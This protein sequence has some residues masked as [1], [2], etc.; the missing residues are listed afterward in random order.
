MTEPLVHGQPK[1][2]PVLA[3]HRFDE[4]RLSDYLRTRLPGFGGE[5]VVQQFQGGQS[6][7]TYAI[8]AAGHR[9]VLRKKPPGKLLPSAHA[10]ERE[11][12]VM[13]ALSATDVP[14]PAMRLLIEDPDVIGTPFFLMDHIDGRVL[15]DVCLPSVA[16]ENRHAYYDELARVM[17][18]LHAVDPIAVGLGDFGRPTNYIA[19]QIDRWS[20][21]YLL[22]KPEDAPAMDRLMEWLPA[23]IPPD[24]RTSV[25]HGDYRLGNMLFHLTEPRVLAVLDWEL[26][27]LGH[28]LADLAYNC[29][30][31]QLPSAV[32][33]IADVP[34]PGLPSQAEYLRMYERHSGKPLP[35]LGYYIVFSLFRWAAIAAGVYRRALDGNAADARGREAGEK[36]KLLAEVAWERVA[37]SASVK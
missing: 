21:Q 22:S 18:A 20:K 15:I 19:R 9:Y 12:R 33:G 8:N 23:H 1:L 24:E 11:F 14:V 16:R 4:A 37:A 35:D 26:A 31:W 34:T 17:A 32:G 27:T 36:Y 29:L 6:N 5:I 25:V 7:P 28:P 10:V 3:N 2:V 13:S 30:Y